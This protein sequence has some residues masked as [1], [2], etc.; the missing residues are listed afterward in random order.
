MVSQR[1]N[2]NRE[3]VF[4]RNAFLHLMTLSVIFSTVIFST[5]EKFQSN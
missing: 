5:D 3:D 1:H 2:R 4:L